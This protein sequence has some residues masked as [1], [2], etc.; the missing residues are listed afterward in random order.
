LAQNHVLLGRQ[1]CTP[2]VVGAFDLGHA[3]IL[4]RRDAR[5]HRRTQD[6]GSIAGELAQQLR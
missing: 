6:L 4:P 3:R 5:V 2:F 1:Q